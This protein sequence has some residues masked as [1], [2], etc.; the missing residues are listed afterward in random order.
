MPISCLV[1]LYRSSSD[2]TK[3]HIHHCRQLTASLGAPRVL[4]IMGAGGVCPSLQGSLTHSKQSTG[5][6]RADVP[7]QHGDVIL[8]D[9]QMHG[10]PPIDSS[11]KVMPT[12]LGIESLKEPAMRSTA[13][14]DRASARVSINIFYATSYDHSTA[15][16]GR[17][18]VSVNHAVDRHNEDAPKP[19][20][21]CAFDHPTHSTCLG[22]A[23]GAAWNS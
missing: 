11:M 15:R 10:V 23:L 14:V 4:R 6:I 2:A 18:P 20:Y 8:L 12:S 5:E 7:M 21:R 16:G 13:A 9:G 19:C 22:P 3:P 17:G 1:N